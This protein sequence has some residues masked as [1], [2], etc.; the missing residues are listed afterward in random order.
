MCG[1]RFF[2]SLLSEAIDYILSIDISRLLG[3]G[4]T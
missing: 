2:L 4:G 3:L 1:D